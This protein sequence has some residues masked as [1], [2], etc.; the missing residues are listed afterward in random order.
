M[1]GFIINILKLTR[2]IVLGVRNDQEFR[3]LLFLLISLLIGSTFF[4]SQAEGWS[5]ID[6]LYF[7]VMTMS[8]VGYGDLV[9][10]TTH[11]K[12]FTIIFTFLSIGVFVS[13]ITKI[14]AVTLDQNKKTV[15]KIKAKSRKSSK[16]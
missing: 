7:S 13:L 2:A 5:A 4:F 1:I 11:S 6:S 10:T 12:L 14:V 9:P 15:E 3:I 16:N 8:T